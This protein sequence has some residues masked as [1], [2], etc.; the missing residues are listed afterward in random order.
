MANED[1]LKKAYNDGFIDGWN[2]KEY[3]TD[4]SEPITGAY[5]DGFIDGWNNTTSRLYDG[6]ETPKRNDE[7]VAI[8][9]E[10]WE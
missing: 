5:H 6:A 8:I 1:M 2:K 4:Y 9:S 7:G 3:N 10:D